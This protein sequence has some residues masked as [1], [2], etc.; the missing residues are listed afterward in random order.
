[1]VTVCWGADGGTGPPKPRSM[2]CA[3]SHGRSTPVTRHESRSCGPHGRGGK[4]QV[5]VFPRRRARDDVVFFWQRRW[6][7]LIMI[8]CHPRLCPCMLWRFLRM[9]L[10]PS[11][12]SVLACPPAA[13]LLQFTPQW[14][15][16]LRASPGVTNYELDQILGNLASFVPNMVRLVP[17][18]RHAGQIRTSFGRTRFPSSTASSHGRLRQAGRD[19]EVVRH[20]APGGIPGIEG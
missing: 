8:V 5:I 9:R 11:H 2:R 1:M 3:Q 12:M 20:R 6:Q 18:Q 16:C 15:R 7:E 14:G 13:R 17:N 4:K 19:G 10:R